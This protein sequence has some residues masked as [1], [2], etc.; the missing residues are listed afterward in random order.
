MNFCIPTILEFKDGFLFLELAEIYDAEGNI[1]TQ[2]IWTDGNELLFSFETIFHQLIFP[3][4]CTYPGL[5]IVAFEPVSRFRRGSAISISDFVFWLKDIDDVSFDTF[6]SMIDLYLQSRKINVQPS[7]YPLWLRKFRQQISL[8]PCSSV[9]V[10][11][12]I[13]NFQFPENFAQEK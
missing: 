10:L 1:S 13:K 9:M 5:K 6:E 2:L 11:E 8:S 12:E 4:L 3:Q 7:D